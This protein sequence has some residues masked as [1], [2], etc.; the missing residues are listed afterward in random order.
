MNADKL[1]ECFSRAL[2]IP[3]DR[4][5]DDLA[6]NTISEWDS[7]GHM[8][9]VAEIETAFDVMFDTDDILG[10][11]TV[12]KASRDP[13]PVRR[14]VRCCLRDGSRWS[15]A[16]AVASAPRSRGHSRRKAPHCCSPPG[17]R[18][19][20]TL[21]RELG[22]A[23]RPVRA[24][25][26]DLGDPAFAK[27]ADHL[28]PQGPRPAGRAGEQR[29]HPPAGADRHD[30]G[31]ADA[32]AARG[33]R[34]GRHR[35]SPS[36]RRVSWTRARS[37]S[38]VNLA[39]IAGTQ[40]M[41]GVTAYSASKAAVVGY[42]LS[43]AKELAPKGIRVNAIAP[44]LHRHRHG[45]GRQPR[46]VRAPTPE[47]PH[48]PHRNAG[49]RGRRGGVPGLRPVALRDR[50]GDRRGRGHDVVIDAVLKHRGDAWR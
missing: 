46:L 27:R 29:R 13:G 9:L 41:E 14:G 3:L 24:L 25:R 19:W 20:M 8:A 4:V 49:G 10:M 15:P 44:G 17:A 28:R 1:R 7:V 48:G 42:T 21:A 39:S 37:P 33:E 35:P 16:R 30:L 34:A 11:S 2:G 18:A 22:A 12:A 43:S 6:Y 40:G 31:R 36:T 5:T 38:I 45:A 23:D 26:G 47:H 50:P 32:G